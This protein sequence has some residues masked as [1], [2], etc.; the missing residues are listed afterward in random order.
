[1]TDFCACCGSHEPPERQ[2]GR[3]AVR[4]AP[5]GEHEWDGH[6]YEDIQIVRNATVIVSRCR[7][8]GR[9]EIGWERQEDTEEEPIEGA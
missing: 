6:I 7:E 8:C 1:M 4:I 9:I 2:E 5:D 3:A